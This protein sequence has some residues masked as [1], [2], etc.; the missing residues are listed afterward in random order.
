M[1]LELFNH[2]RNLYNSCSKEFYEL[3]EE[4]Q[5]EF[6]DIIFGIKDRPE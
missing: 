5:Q 2:V 4:T 6:F 3:P 1:S